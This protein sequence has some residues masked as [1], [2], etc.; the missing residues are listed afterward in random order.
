MLRISCCRYRSHAAHLLWS[1]RTS[2]L[3]GQTKNNRPFDCSM[4]EAAAMSQVPRFGCS[5]VLPG[6]PCCP[7]STSQRRC[8]MILSL[9]HL[10][11]FQHHTKTAVVEQ[12]L[13]Q[14]F[15]GLFSI[16]R[17]LARLHGHLAAASTG[18]ASLHRASFAKVRGKDT[19][20]CFL[21]PTLYALRLRNTFYFQKVTTFFRLGGGLCSSMTT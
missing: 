11:R 13:C 9:V 6:R 8:P 18:Q 3:S 2:I 10:S 19:S 15:F 17:W 5:P 14:R 7:T 4:N 20:A 12:L 1:S 21:R 16:V